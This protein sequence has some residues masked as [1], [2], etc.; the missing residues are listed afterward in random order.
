M[1]PQVETDFTVTLQSTLKPTR[2]PTFGVG[3]RFKRPRHTLANPAPDSY[4]LKTCFDGES[5]TIKKNHLTTSFKNQSSRDAYGKQFIPT[6]GG[7]PSPTI[8]ASRKEMP[9]PGTYSYTNM[10]IGTDA[11][12]FT[13]KS[14]VKN[15]RGP[16]EM[17][18][19]QEIPGPGHYKS[20]G[21]D[22]QGKYCVST[23]P[24]SRASVWSPPKSKRFQEP[25]SHTYQKPEC[26][27]YNPSD[28]HSMHDSYL[29]STMKT[30]G[31]KKMITLHP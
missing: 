2:S 14:R 11:L 29:L 3:D 6:R 5:P 9:G 8:A 10:A 1:K 4:T 26:A 30:L 22:P 17:A 21:I 24:N 15:L 27:T 19:Q 28:T 25:L 23:I 7:S 18:K 20:I 13:L 12:K 31:V 16:E